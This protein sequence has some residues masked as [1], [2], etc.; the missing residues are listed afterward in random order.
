MGLP[1]ED[2]DI[3]GPVT[4]PDPEEF[5][6][7][8]GLFDVLTQAGVGRR[9]VGRD[10]EVLG[11]TR[12][13]NENQSRLMLNALGAAV[14]RFGKVQVQLRIRDFKDVALGGPQSDG[15]VSIIYGEKPEMLILHFA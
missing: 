5:A 9:N 6:W 8:V 13:L 4:L 1:F 10:P 11:R 15:I 7:Q 12:E 3:G 14:G 2:V